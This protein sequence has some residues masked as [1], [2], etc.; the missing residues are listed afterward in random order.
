MKT[1]YISVELTAQ[2][3]ER[4][5]TAP[6]VVRYN[7]MEGIIKYRIKFQFFFSISI[8]NIRIVELRLSYR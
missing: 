1:L 7:H 4:S 2:L 3:T 6:G 8:S 5:Y